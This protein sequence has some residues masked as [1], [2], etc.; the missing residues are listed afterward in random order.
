MGTLL[1]EKRSFQ[2]ERIKKRKLL[3][4][5]SIQKLDAKSDGAAEIWWKL[6]LVL[7]DVVENKTYEVKEVT[8]HKVDDH[9]PE[10]ILYHIKWKN[11]KDPKWDTWE[12]ESSFIE[13]QYI[14]DY[15]E[16]Y[17]AEKA[18]VPT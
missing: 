1:G 4:C 10:K 18:E 6:E 14:K 5:G 12:S 9:D 2:S 11:Y 13:R 15:W 8:D 17:N 7:D 3:L 16:K